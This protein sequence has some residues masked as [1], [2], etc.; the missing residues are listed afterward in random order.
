MGIS[1]DVLGMG[2]PGN[3]LGIFRP[4][5]MLGWAGDGHRLG[6]SSARLFMVRTGH[7]LVSGKAGLSI[8]CTWA[9]YG[10][11]GRGLSWA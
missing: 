4:R 3:G 7:L 6:C 9:G 5:H 1:S 10:W 2:S 8:G 11:A